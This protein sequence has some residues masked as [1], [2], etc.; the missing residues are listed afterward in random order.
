[1]GFFIN[2]VTLVHV[3]L[4][5][6]LQPFWVR[7]LICSNVNRASQ[8]HTFKVIKIEIRRYKNLQTIEPN[9]N[10]EDSENK[11]PHI[12]W[13]KNFVS[14]DDVCYRGELVAC[15]WFGVIKSKWF[16]LT[17]KGGYFQQ[18]TP[19]HHALVWWH[20]QD[21]W[22]FSFVPLLISL[23]K[24]CNEIAFSLFNLLV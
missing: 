19:S 6:I 9:S 5:S 16:F 8:L 20:H 12:N 23:R 21:H 15:Y 10:Q 1:M 4:A 7:P 13:Y 18:I 22:F 2:N 11:I 14:S 17:S 3:Y 24:L